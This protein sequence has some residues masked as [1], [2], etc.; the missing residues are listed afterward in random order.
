MGQIFDGV[1][2]WHSSLVAER[3][4]SLDSGLRITDDGVGVVSWLDARSDSS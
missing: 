2:Q 3:D 4:L 1:L